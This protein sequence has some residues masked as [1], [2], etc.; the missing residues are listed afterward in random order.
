MKNTMLPRLKERRRHIRLHPKGDAYV[1]IDRR[2][3]PLHDWSPEGLLIHPYRGGLIPN[4][5][6]RVEAVIRDIQA[7]DGTIRLNGMVLV[8]RIDSGGLAARW[9]IMPPSQREKLLHYYARKPKK[10]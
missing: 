7:P 2:D 1:R 3:Y 6:A 10:A 8:T 9:L 5:K 4:Q